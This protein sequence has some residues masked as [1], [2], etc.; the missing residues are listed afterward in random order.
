MS[1]SS[2]S[3]IYSSLYS[4]LV[5]KTKSSDEASEATGSSGTSSLADILE[6]NTS[7]ELSAYLNYDSSGNYSSGTS[8]LDYLTIDDD[9][10]GL[11]SNS[12]NSDNSLRDILYPGSSEASASG[13]FD[14]LISAKSEEI[15]NM[16]SLAMEKLDNTDK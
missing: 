8:L 4:S 14:S 7:E 9:G 11:F 12:Q 6:L 13:I 1:I 5:S 3:S 2:I 15:E 10:T 16:I